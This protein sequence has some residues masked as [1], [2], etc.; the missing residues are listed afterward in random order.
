MLFGTV[1]API[2]DRTEIRVSASLIANETPP[3][4]LGTIIGARSRARFSP[5]TST[6]TAGD[7]PMRPS[8]AGLT[9]IV[10]VKTRH[11][12]RRATV[13]DLSPEARIE[14]VDGATRDG[15]ATSSA[16]SP[17]AERKRC[18]VCGLRASSAAARPLPCT[19]A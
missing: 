8:G 12:A 10:L 7:G 1:A 18:C 15:Q 17:P 4:P 5:L 19:R 13:L 6:L 11:R 3:L 9:T 14:G 16:T 2:G